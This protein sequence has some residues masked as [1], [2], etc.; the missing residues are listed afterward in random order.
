MNTIL[1]TLL[2]FILLAAAGFAADNFA[3]T[4]K[5]AEAGDSTAQYNI[6]VMY[7]NVIE[8]KVPIELTGSN[9]NYSLV[10]EQ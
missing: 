5:R 3:E 10:R 8:R 7:A 2:I 9:S 1:R 4:K 6:G